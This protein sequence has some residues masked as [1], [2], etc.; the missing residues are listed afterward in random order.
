MSI[1]LFK[2][3]YNAQATGGGDS[4]VK[5]W[6][7][8]HL[9]DGKSSGIEHAFDVPLYDVPVSINTCYCIGV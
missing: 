3:W 2:R 1:V 8:N 7:I 4:F 5:L 9:I 6:D